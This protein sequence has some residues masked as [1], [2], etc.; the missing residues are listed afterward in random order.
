MSLDDS[1]PCGVGH[2]ETTVMD[3][4]LYGIHLIKNEIFGWLL[5]MLRWE[6]CAANYY[7]ATL[8][9]ICPLQDFAVDLLCAIL[10]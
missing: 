2:V 10:F 6:E 7:R 3:E 9:K 1:V 8:C 4:A 5:S